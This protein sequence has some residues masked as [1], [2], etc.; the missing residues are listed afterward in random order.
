LPQA[1]TA[2]RRFAVAWRNRS[3]RLITPVAVLVHRGAGY[4]FQYLDGVE[5]SVPGFRPFIGFPDVRRVYESVRLW[6]FFDLR[7]MDSKRAD[8]PQYIH[9]LGLTPEASR[10]DI[11]S[12]SGG[13]KRATVSISPR[14]RPL[15]TTVPRKPCS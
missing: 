14:R 1:S 3:R 6:P 10:L 9:W 7:V 15:A 5:E 8:F 13:N 12:R 4:R 11:L 2:V